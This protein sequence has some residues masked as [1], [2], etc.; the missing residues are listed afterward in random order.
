MAQTLAQLI[1][2]FTVDAYDTNEQLS[3]FLQVFQDE[4]TT[5]ISATALG[6]AV[7]VVS[8]DL[9]GDEREVALK[10]IHDAVASRAELV[11]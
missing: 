10:V 5:L 3:G 6:V 8:L 1:D 9:E 11:L 7:E 4:V 2:E